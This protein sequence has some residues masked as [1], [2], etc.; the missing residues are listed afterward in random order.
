MSAYVLR[1]ATVLTMNDTLD[2]IEG[3]VVVRDGVITQVG[4]P[5][6]DGFT[7]IDVS[8]SVVLPGFVPANVSV[9]VILS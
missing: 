2:E 5:A 6:P 7:T 3:P 8:G 4:G 9:L 1:G